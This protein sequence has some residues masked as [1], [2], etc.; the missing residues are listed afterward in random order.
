[1]LS[2]GLVKL[3]LLFLYR[4]ILTVSSPAVN[5]TWWLSLFLVTLNTV[6][7]V[8]LAIFSCIPVEAA[9]DIAKMQTAR[10]IDLSVMFIIQGSGNVITDLLI[11]VLPIP[12][13]WKLAL[14]KKRKITL[15]ILFAVGS[16]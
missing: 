8:C 13:I 9:W 14:E 12:S 7:F 3:S 16:L 1:M 2:M 11:L 5:F 15:S 4:R 10:C 6:P